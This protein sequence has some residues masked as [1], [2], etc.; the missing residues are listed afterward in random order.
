MSKKKIAL[1]VMAIITIVLIIIFTFIYNIFYS[2]TR[3]PKGEFLA[4]ST[5]SNGSYT[6]KTYL[7]NGGAT[8]GFA[9]RGEVIANNKSNKVKNVY[10]DYRVDSVDISWEYEDTVIINGHEIELPNGKYDWRRD[11]K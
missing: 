1:I 4:E 2:M 9:V 10:W 8:T 7:C 3:L 6:I 5:S 11:K